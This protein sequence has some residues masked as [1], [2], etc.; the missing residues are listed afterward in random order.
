DSLFEE[1]FKDVVGSLEAEIRVDGTVVDQS[2]EGNLF[3]TEEMI[4]EGEIM[5]RLTDDEN[6]PLEVSDEAID[7]E[8]NLVGE[9]VVAQVDGYIPATETYVVQGGGLLTLS[10]VAA[11]VHIGLA[12]GGTTQLLKLSGGSPKGTGQTQSRRIYEIN[13]RLYRSQGLSIGRITGDLDTLPYDVDG[14][15]STALFTGDIPRPFKTTW[16]KT[17][18][19]LIVQT[20]PLPAHI[21]SI[22]L[23]SEVQSS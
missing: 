21:L 7:I 14:S 15:A 4:E 2:E 22:V 13:L 16:G 23:E 17:D 10:A 12:Y 8:I 18:E 9:T 5:I 3:I 6:I 11:V 1:Y 19:I 20:K